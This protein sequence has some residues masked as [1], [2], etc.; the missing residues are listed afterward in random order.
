VQGIVEANEFGLKVAKSYRKNIVYTP[1]KFDEINIYRE[2]E[3]AGRKIIVIGGS[4]AQFGRKDVTRLLKLLQRVKEHLN[5]EV[6]P[7]ALAL[8]GFFSKS[9]RRFKGQS[10]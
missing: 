4:K 9:R 7:L 5:R 1:D 3:K 10:N 8:I 2:A 6:F